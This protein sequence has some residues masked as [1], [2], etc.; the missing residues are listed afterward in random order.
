[1]KNNIA[2]QS[3]CRFAD[4]E[5]L[6]YHIDDFDTLPLKR[7]LLVYHLSEATLAGRDII[8]DQNGKYNLRIRHILEQIYVHYPE[9]KNKTEYLALSEYLQRV[10]FSSGIHHHYGCEKFTPAF[11][12][13]YLRQAIKELQEEQSILLEYTA[14]EL[15]DIIAEVFDPQRSPKRTEQSGDGDLI[16][17]SSVNFYET[18]ISQSDVETLYQR[19]A[20][21]ASE[22]DKAT[23]PS[24]GL[25]TRLCRNDDGEL[26]ESTYKIGGLY[27][28]ALDVISSHLKAA[29]AYT[30]T[31]A[32]RTAILH[33]LTY[34]KTGDLK[35]YNDFCIAWVQDTDVTID[36]INGFTEVYADPLG[37]KG[38]WEGL[39]HIKNAKASERTEKIC[40][41]AKWFEQNA[42]IDERFKKLEPKGISATVVTVAMLGGDSY[43]ATPIGI[44]L[45]NADW[46]RA[47][48]GSKS[49]TIENIHAAY[50]I[51]SSQSGM[52]EAFIAD[53]SVRELL[54][55]YDGLTDELHTDLHECL[56]HGSGQLLPGVSPDALGAYASVNEETRADLFALY[57]M[58]DER[59]VELGLLPDADAYKACYYRYL[60]NG[61]VTQLVRISLGSNIEEAHMRN[62]A[63]IARYALERGRTEGTIE[64]NGI[65]LV[66][67]DYKALR[68]Y[69]AELLREVQRLKS[70][71]DFYAC[72]ALVERYAIHI[73]YD[74]HK[75]ILELYKSLH[76]APYRG[77]VNPKLELVWSDD[78]IV[79]VRADY[80]ESYEEQMLRYSREYRLLSLD[81]EREEKLRNPQPSQA[82][83]AV[84]KDLRANLRSSMDGIVSSSMREKGLH[85]GI[86]FGLTMEYIQGR[87][88]ALPQSKNLAGYLLNRD[89]RE[90]KLIGQLT[91]PAERLTFTEATYL[92][93]QAFANPELRD[94]LAK[95][96]FDRCSVAPQ[97]AL[98]WLTQPKRYSEVITTAYTILARHFTKGYQIASP[99]QSE[100]LLSLAF[101]TLNQQEEYMTQKQRAAL[102]MLKRWGRSN[103]SIK[104]RILTSPSMQTW[105]QSSSCILLEYADDLKFELNFE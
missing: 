55:K 86:N 41:E 11:T 3:V 64:L 46:I 6:R 65:N 50:R 95:H 8:F 54:H 76:L 80:T 72:K 82:T 48:Y 83:M 2:G 78:T 7:K 98:A 101:D 31:E 100:L 14:L 58:G 61:L 68:S 18:G 17:K 21:E 70:E 57:Y 39:V 93:E 34:Y 87:A 79:D 37:L 40:A 85:Y 60:L 103:T 12:E 69:F 13:S 88:K 36:F 42:P 104:Q 77:F 44:N 94:C 105:E 67:H 56:G 74:M 5:I 30:D 24:Y 71:G 25:N 28:S 38:S 96:L 22:E 91:Y 23:P 16:K 73:D 84:A 15:D 99:T 20:E 33:L 53:D 43:P 10:W 47:E 49:V 51:A 29:L 75:Q 52:D 9:E 102:L 26:Y 97:F 63:L 59:L 62:R 66:I 45:P 32:Q 81:T 92:A 89:V 90:L 19:Q 27:G 35:K 4:I 1:M